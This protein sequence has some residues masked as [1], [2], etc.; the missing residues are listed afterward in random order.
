M[1]DWTLASGFFH[2]SYIFI[3][4]CMS[5]LDRSTIATEQPFAATAAAVRKDSRRR[6]A[7]WSVAIVVLLFIFVPTVQ[8]FTMWRRSAFQSR[9]IRMMMSDRHDRSIQM[10]GRLTRQPSVVPS[11]SFRSSSN[12]LF[13]PAAT[14]HQMD[15]NVRQRYQYQQQKLFSSVA[16]ELELTTDEE[17]DFA[18]NPQNY[19]IHNNNNNNNIDDIES[20]L[21]SRGIR[22]RPVEGGR[23]NV[24]DPLG[25][26]KHFG[27]RSPAQEAAL[28]ER[29]Q[30]KPGDEG[31]HDVSQVKVPGV[32][33][34]RTREQARIVLEKLYNAPRN[35]FHAA[36]TEVMD[37]D[38]KEVGPVGNGY[39]TCL[40]LFSGEGFDY[41]LG[42]PP[43]T[44]LFVDNLD[45]SFGVLQEFK[46]W[47]EDERYLKVWHN[48]GFDRHVLWNEGIDVKGFGGDTMH[49]ARLHDTGRMAL[50]KGY[51]LESLSEDML[52]RKKES[53]KS[54]F[55]KRRLRSDGTE[56]LLVDLPPIGELQR[57]PTH[58]FNWILYAAY[59]AQST[60]KL[61]EK[62][63]KDLEGTKWLQGKNLWEYYWMHMRKFGEVLTDMERRGVRVDAREYL[64]GIEKQARLDKE[65]HSQVFR[66]WASKQYPKGEEA[67]GLG[68]NPASSIQLQTFLFG[69]S[70]NLKT[71]ET[72]PTE[73]TFTL[74]RSDFPEDAL[75]AFEAKW[76]EEED[77]HNLAL[78]ELGKIEHG[79]NQYV[80][81]L[82][83]SH[84]LVSPWN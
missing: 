26:A 52:A 32:T 36:D 81:S 83:N 45:D 68:L 63:Q 17:D 61:R 69:G 62:L 65:H 55:G 82:L 29:A 2:S 1:G 16:T 57:D 44:A 3:T 77:A 5:L 21:Q 60:F 42:D 8:S 37:I 13:R 24:R 71:K 33:I 6:R 46:D 41:G 64:A 84:V 67:H 72:T 23:W 31:Y 9:Q 12:S 74:P 20:Y 79:G 66:T 51:S 80:T 22:S 4:P 15:S 10:M 11:F 73:R 76:Q 75:E 40:T 50:G 43:G 7:V 78:Q 25:W 18:H 70:K 49:M 30:L 19:M 28:L 35:I 38:V 34:V 56:G 53:M 39:V 14:C 58:R 48:Y 47:L 59:D 54:I 27:R